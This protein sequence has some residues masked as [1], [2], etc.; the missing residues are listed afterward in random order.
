MGI[1]NM[2]TDKEMCEI[3]TRISERPHDIV[4]GLTVGDF[5]QMKMHIVHCMPCRDKVNSVVEEHDDTDLNVGGA[6][7]N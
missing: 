6:S 1:N 7:E 5:Y 4:S 3:I 2:K